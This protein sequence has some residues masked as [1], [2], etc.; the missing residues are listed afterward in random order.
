MSLAGIPAPSSFWRA[1]FFGRRR[2]PALYWYTSLSLFG[3]TE[4]QRHPQHES[5]KSLVYR[6]N[7]DRTA[8]E[9]VVG[10]Y[11]TQSFSKKSAW[12][13]TDVVV[14]VAPLARVSCS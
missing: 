6:L 14:V 10:R 4:S 7:A 2:T 5:R 11:V 9:V 1:G 8:V 3:R 12:A 13:P